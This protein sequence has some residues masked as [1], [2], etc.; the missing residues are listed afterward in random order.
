MCMCFFQNVIENPA[1]VCGKIPDKTGCSR[2]NLDM[3]PH[4][5]VYASF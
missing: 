2:Q 5:K 4:L 3:I 1:Q